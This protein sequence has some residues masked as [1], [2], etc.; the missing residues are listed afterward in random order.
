MRST[1]LARRSVMA[2]EDQLLGDLSAEETE[3]K[4]GQ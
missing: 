3:T 4:C 1:E 2:G